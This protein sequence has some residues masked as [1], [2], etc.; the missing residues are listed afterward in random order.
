VGATLPIYSYSKHFPHTIL[1]QVVSKT[2]DCNL[3]Q[4]YVTIVIMLFV[5]WSDPSADLSE[6]ACV[7]SKAKVEPSVQST[8]QERG[9]K[10][11]GLHQVEQL[12][13]LQ[14][15]ALKEDEKSNDRPSTGCERADR[16]PGPL[17]DCL[18]L[19]WRTLRRTYCLVASFRRLYDV[20]HTHPLF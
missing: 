5:A 10:S 14:G 6:R 1:A 8:E 19:H 20:V 7:S 11:K 3:R 18:P 2:V 17:E 12:A 15:R 9:A 16:P 13:R 4:Y